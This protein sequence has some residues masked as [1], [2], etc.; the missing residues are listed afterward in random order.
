MSCHFNNAE[1]DVFSQL[2]DSLLAEMKEII[3]AADNVTIAPRYVVEEVSKI[4]FIFF[5]TEFSTRNVKR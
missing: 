3:N 5:F 4:M 1:F 2:P